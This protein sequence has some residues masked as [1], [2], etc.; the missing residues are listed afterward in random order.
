MVKSTSNLNL[1]NANSFQIG[2][3]HGTYLSLVEPSGEGVRDFAAKFVNDFVS[4]LGCV[5]TNDNGTDV[6]NQVVRIA[7]ESFDEAMKRADADFDV[8][9]PMASVEEVNEREWALDDQ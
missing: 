1:S 2:A 8:G 5:N 6:N 7:C 9:F 3:T 4:C